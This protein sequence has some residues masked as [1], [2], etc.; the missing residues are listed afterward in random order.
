[1][2]EVTGLHIRRAAMDYLARREHAF[3][4][5]TTKLE[6]KFIGRAETRT[7]ISAENRDETGAEIQPEAIRELIVEQISLLA[8]ENLQSD[9]RYV[10]SFIN[11]RRSQGKGP[12]RIQ[13]ELEQRGVSAAL[14]EDHLD[15]EVASWQDLAEQVY[16]KKF[17]QGKELDHAEKAKRLRFMQYRGFSW[18]HINALFN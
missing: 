8:S 18:A 13:R 2:A 9:Q 11:G 15:L 3:Q 7:A 12:L 16:I 10:E 1:V 17:G 5:L 6:R 14:I 4:E